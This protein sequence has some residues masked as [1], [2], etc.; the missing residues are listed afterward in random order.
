MVRGGGELQAPVADHDLDGRARI[1]QVREPARVRGDA[2]DRRVELVE[3]E[4]VAGPAVGG[5]RAAPEADGSD[6]VQARAELLEDLSDR[7]PARV[8]AER[9]VEPAGREALDPVDRRPVDEDVLMAW[10]LDDA[11]DAVERALGVE[12]RLRE[13]DQEEQRGQ[14][15]RERRPPAEED[16]E[17]GDPRAEDEPD[18]GRSGEARRGEASERDE[19]E[20]RREERDGRGAE[21]GAASGPEE[22][23]ERDHE[24]VLE[25]RREEP[26]RQQRVEDPA[27]DAAERE[28]EVELRQ[29]VDRRPLLGETAVHEQREQEEVRRVHADERGHRERDD[30][31]DR[32]RGREGGHRREHADR[33]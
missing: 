25:D 16:E 28:Q 8:V 19:D 10:A 9:H 30:A 21:A 27:Q 5:E 12:R 15:D 7:A 22:Q 3:G 33:P 4:A 11:E 14:A 29:P 23:R 13:R 31:Q 6:R 18:G 24:R 1:P 32:R 2:R 26:R 20:E 17:H